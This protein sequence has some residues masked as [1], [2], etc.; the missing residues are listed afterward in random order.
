MDCLY[1]SSTPKNGTPCGII[2]RGDPVRDFSGAME[3]AP[4]V[5]SLLV[6]EAARTDLGIEQEMKRGD[7]A[8]LYSLKP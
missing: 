7:A 5:A 3:V 6:V 2:Q 8:F 1:S 4:L